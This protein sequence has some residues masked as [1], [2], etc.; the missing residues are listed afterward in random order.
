M[1]ERESIIYGFALHVFIAPSPIYV[2]A[3]RV[4]IAPSPGAIYRSRLSQCGTNNDQIQN[5]PT[6][7]CYP[8]ESAGIK[9]YQLTSFEITIGLKMHRH[10]LNQSGK[11]FSQNCL[12]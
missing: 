5:F 3:L 12:N 4:F 10:G 8:S 9:Y 7:S 6:Y 1:T 11:C 2:F